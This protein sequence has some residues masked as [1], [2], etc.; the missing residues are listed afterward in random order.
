MFEL[1]NVVRTV[2][3]CF[4]FWGDLPEVPEANGD[5]EGKLFSFNGS[6]VIRFN[7]NFRDSIHTT[8]KIT[9]LHEETSDS[10][11]KCMTELMY[12]FS[13]SQFSVEVC[14]I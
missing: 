1:A 12:L 10:E 7:G 3:C 8:C 6:Y 4:R 2:C 13:G 14:L 5:K 11:E 9:L